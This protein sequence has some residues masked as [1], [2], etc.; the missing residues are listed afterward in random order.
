M[1][2]QGDELGHGPSRV[3]VAHGGDVAGGLVEHQREGRL[4]KR[5]DDPV[6]SHD[7]MLRVNL[8]PELAHHNAVHPH[9]SRAHEALGAAPARHAGTGKEAL[10]AHGVDAALAN[11]VAHR[12]VFSLSG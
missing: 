7:V 6:N 11:G 9:A 3:R 5:A 4:G 8:A 12:S 2:V 10:E 1:L